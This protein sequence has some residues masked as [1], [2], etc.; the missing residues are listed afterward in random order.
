MGLRLA[1]STVYIPQFVRKRQLG[2]LF[3]A[4]AAAF[5]AAVPSTK[6]L[7][8]DDSLKLY[9]AFTRERAALA[10]KGG[11]ATEIQPALFENA[12]Q[13]GRKFRSDFGLNTTPEVMKMSSIIYRLLK[14]DFSGGPQGN[15]II[16]RCF[17]ADYYSND[18]CRLISSLDE[19]LLA[20]LSGGGKL[21]FSQRL[22]AG[23]DCCRAYLSSAGE[24]K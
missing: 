24:L 23:S 8:I 18:I 7:S 21:S 6:G 4:T 10:I 1:A 16:R 11:Y 19:G 3:K 15:I 13:M 20:G 14:I 17:F 9:A 2:M 5:R 22:T 12:Y